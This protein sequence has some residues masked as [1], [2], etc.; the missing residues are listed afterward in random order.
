[1]PT[2]RLRDSFLCAAIEQER[3]KELCHTMVQVS[4]GSKDLNK[5]VTNYI[6]TLFPWHKNI[7]KQQLQA[8]ADEYR[9]MFG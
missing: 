2:Y 6:E 9:R 8:L 3:D 5:A 4:M 1:M 7:R